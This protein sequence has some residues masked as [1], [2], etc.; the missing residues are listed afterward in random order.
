VKTSRES[1]QGWYAT[2][3]HQLHLLSFLAAGLLLAAAGCQTHRPG[4]PAARTGDEMVAA[5]RLIHTGTRV[6]LWMDPGGYDAYRIERRFSPM[7]ESDWETSKAKVKGLTTPNRYGLRRAV[8]TEEEAEQVRGGGW[9]LSL[10]QKVVDQ[11][12]LHYDA[13]G[14]SRQCFKVLH[15]QRDLSVHFLLDLDGTIYQTLDLKE[16][17]WHATSSN[18]RSVGIEIANVGAYRPGKPSPLNE[19]YHT[20]AAG[21]TVLEVPRRFGKN[22]QRTV[23]FVGQPA[24]PGRVSGTIQGAELEQFDYTPEQY[25]ALVKLTAA[26]CATFPKVRCDYPREAAGGLA[27][28]KLPDP[29]LSRYQGILGHWHIQ[30]D[31]VDP[32]PAFQWDYVIQG[33]RQWLEG[34]SLR[35]AFEKGASRLTGSGA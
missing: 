16:R 10:L 1:D 11:F 3:A 21:R 17:A 12:V 23:G 31:K 20:N 18:S 6:V 24:R 30:T 33:A 29:E 25:A 28:R 8:L 26:L 14:T 22:T 5:G 7:E 4:S 9:D 2:R 19:W 27:S 32:G 13:S 35:P 15:D 34:N